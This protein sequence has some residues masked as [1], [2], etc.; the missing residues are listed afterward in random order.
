MPEITD[1]LNLPYPLLSDI[2]DG[3]EQMERLTKAID[4]CALIVRTTGVSSRDTA[5]P[6]PQEGVA[7]YRTDLNAFQVF[8]DGDWV[9][10]ESPLQMRTQGFNLNGSSNVSRPTRGFRLIGGRWD[11]TTD[12]NGYLIILLPD[13]GFPSTLVSA[14][15]GM[16]SAH[17]SSSKI[18][19]WAAVVNDAAGDSP[20]VSNSSQIVVRAFRS[21]AANGAA[22]VR[23]T[24]LA[25]GY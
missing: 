1:N 6:F 12:A 9:T 2:P 7:C 22:A 17:T 18:N 14:Q 16:F 15:V 23:L 20:G 11:G 4:A 24:Y 25:V 19:G 10:S 21:G 8:L 13:G 3:S 5:F